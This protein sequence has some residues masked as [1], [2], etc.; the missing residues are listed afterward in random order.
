MREFPDNIGARGIGE[1]LEFAQVFVDVVT[2]TRALERRADENGAF[3]WRA[4]GDQ[5]FCD[6]TA[7]GR[8]ERL[9][10]P[11]YHPS[12]AAQTGGCGMDKKVDQAL[13]ATTSVDTKVDHA[14]SVGEAMDKEVDQALRS[15]ETLDKKVDQ[16][17]GIAETWDKEVDHALRATQTLDSKV[18]HAFRLETSFSRARKGMDT[19]FDQAFGVRETLD[20]EV[21][22]A[23][24]VAAPMDKTFD[25]AIIAAA[26]SV[27]AEQL[28][29][30]VFQRSFSWTSRC[31]IPV[32][33]SFRKRT[34]A[35]S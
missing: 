31:S 3:L 16:A 26:M 15:R 17:S 24:D 22:Q 6:T 21:D 1:P 20:K 14:F 5:F 30:I 34:V 9:P 10:L 32:P 4:E 2:G 28:S 12:T 13:R 8:R 23:L 29:S 33:L 19:P 11:I 27:G 18:D 25:H 7:R 35:R